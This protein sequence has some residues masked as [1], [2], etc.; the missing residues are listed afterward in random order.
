MKEQIA[1]LPEL[2][3]A[4][5]QL[6]LV[7]LFAGAVISLPL[8]VWLT[9]HRRFE[10]GV[11][12]VASVIQTIPSLALLA[13]MVPTL[14]A[15][16][17]VVAALFDV[18]LRTIGFLPALVALTLYSILPMLRNTVIGILE[19]DPAL[20]EAARGVGMTDRQQLWRVELPQALPVIVAGFR[21]ATVWVVGTATLS[22]PVGAPSLGNYI[23]SG[24]Q[25]R[26]FT[27]VTVGC[28]AAAGLALLLDGLIRVIE[29]GTRLRRQRHVIAASTV[30]VCLFLYVGATL[31]VDAIGGSRAAVRI[32]TKAFTEQ[33]ILGE[34]IAGQVRRQ[35][36]LDV[37]SVQSLGSS[38]LFDALRTDAVD[39]A[40]DYS[41][42]IWA[43]IMQRDSLPPDP[44]QVVGLVTDYLAREHQVVAI[45]TLGF[46]NTYA[47]AMRSSAAQQLGIRTISQLAAHAGS[48]EIAGDLEFFARSEWRAVKETYA[49]AFAKKRPMDS[50]LMYRAVANGDVDVITAYTT[51]GRI[52]AFDLVILDDDR[53]AIPPYDAMLLVGPRLARSR[54]SVVV[55]LRALVGR[56]DADRMRR[57]NF[58]VDEKGSTPAR[59]AEQFLD[60]VG[61]EPDGRQLPKR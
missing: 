47:L 10:S 22:T 20:V 34:I 11:L 5:L 26:N 21:T 9:R 33:Y 12:G 40:V 14:A 38:V 25:T 35:T 39:I 58:A 31:V 45:G 52:D 19:V 23:F 17:V 28:V 6:T 8:G 48:M 41:G 57:M 36:G 4:H 55:A 7:A 37:Q 61:A 59:V 1:Q 24:L 13:F 29:R 51:D 46:E 30:V 44:T 42:T 16:G 54:P 3:T 56:I 2:L 60:A 27:A 32:G 15:V 53:G 50:T 18:K 43:T 49:L